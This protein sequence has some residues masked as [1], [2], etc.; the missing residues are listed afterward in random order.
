MIDVISEKFKMRPLN[1]DKFLCYSCNN[2]LINWY[3]MQNKNKQTQPKSN[4]DDQQT[5][6]SSTMSA[7]IMANAYKHIAAKTSGK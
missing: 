1:D 2:W 5:T 3:S 7:T 6:T 4:E